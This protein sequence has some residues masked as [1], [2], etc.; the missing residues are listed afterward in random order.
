MQFED[1]R[2][3]SGR[4]R[5]RPSRQGFRTAVGGGLDLGLRHIPQWADRARSPLPARVGPRKEIAQSLERGHQ[6]VAVDTLGETK[7]A[8]VL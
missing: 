6:L 8:L 4:N 3:F 2:R 1:P 7:V 5:K